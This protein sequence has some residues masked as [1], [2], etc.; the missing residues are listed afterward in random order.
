MT[1][2]VSKKKVGVPSFNQ[3]WLFLVYCISLQCSLT[4]TICKLQSLTR[5][6]RLLWNWICFLFK[7]TIQLW[8]YSVW[9]NSECLDLFFCLTLTYLSFTFI[10]WLLC[11]N[12]LNPLEIPHPPGL[13]VFLL[14]PSIYLHTIKIT[15]TGWDEAVSSSI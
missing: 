4:L 6:N 14:C 7:I 5:T 9:S 10:W 2:K 8:Q 12:S 13:V 11:S 15:C 1:K 3:F